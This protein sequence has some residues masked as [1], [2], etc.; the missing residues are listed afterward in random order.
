MH[1]QYNMVIFLLECQILFMTEEEKYQALVQDLKD[2]IFCKG[3][4]EFTNIAFD[5]QME[6]KTLLHHNKCV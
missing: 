2:T 5:L 4:S 6:Q 1:H 3:R